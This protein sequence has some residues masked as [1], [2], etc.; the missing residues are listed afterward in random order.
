MKRQSSSSSKDGG[1]DERVYHSHHGTPNTKPKIENH[2]F[3]QWLCDVES[4]DDVKK[5][6]T[7]IK[8]NFGLF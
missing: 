6:E 2:N 8:E 4:C 7:G 5:T 1:T 3:L